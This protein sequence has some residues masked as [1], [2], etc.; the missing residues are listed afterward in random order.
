[1][2]VKDLNIP[3][4]WVSW[5]Q[6]PDTKAGW[7]MRPTK[8]PVDKRILGYWESGFNDTHM[9]VC[10]LVEAKT[11]KEVRTL[12]AVHWPEYAT[13]TERF[14]QEKPSNFKPNNRFPM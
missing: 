10:A 14:F 13:A 7:D 6:P 11:E 2:A 1:M 3:R 9:M 8:W 12:L 4:W 5:E